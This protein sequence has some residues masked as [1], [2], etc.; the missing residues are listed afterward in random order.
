MDGERGV[1][2]NDSHRA[3]QMACFVE[4]GLS[5]S[6]ASLRCSGWHIH[7]HTPTLSLFN[8][9]ASRSSSSNSSDRRLVLLWSL[10]V[11]ATKQKT[12]K[13][14]PVCEPP[15]GRTSP[16]WARLAACSYSPSARS[17]SDQHGHGWQCPETVDPGS[18]PSGLLRHRAH[19][20]K[21]QFCSGEAGPTPHYQDRGES[22]S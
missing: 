19:F 13:P 9:R 17:H 1:E 15:P 5:E 3:Q 11:A 10:S 20:G 2:L 8:G 14:A 16:L 18:G 4:A 12:N 6:V 21:G 22:L 7:S